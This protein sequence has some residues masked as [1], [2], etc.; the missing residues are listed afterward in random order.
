MMHNLEN[1]FILKYFHLNILIWFIYISPSDPL[2]LVQV[3][4]QTRIK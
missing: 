4:V 1:R 2:F 3:L